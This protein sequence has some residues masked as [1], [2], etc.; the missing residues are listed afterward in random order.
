MKSTGGQGRG[1]STVN[2]NNA[3]GQKQY[4][5]PTLKRLIPELYKEMAK[6]Q[7]QFHDPIFTSVQLMK[8]R[9][10]Y[11]EMLVQR[12]Q[13]RT[14][15]VTKELKARREAEIA[16]NKKKRGVSSQGSATR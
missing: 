1:S 11:H 13:K 5:A 12:I 7:R 4:D 8:E 3:P 2:F 9:Y 14:E 16:A 15:E 10:S 6:Q